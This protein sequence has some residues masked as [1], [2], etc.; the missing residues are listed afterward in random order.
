MT[1]AVNEEWMRIY[2]LSKVLANKLCLAKQQHI[3]ARD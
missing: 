3:A 1:V 2:E